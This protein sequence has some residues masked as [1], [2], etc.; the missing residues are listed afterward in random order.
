MKKQGGCYNQCRA[1]PKEQT[2]W[3]IKNIKIYL[4]MD[5]ELA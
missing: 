4:K 5:T 1:K 2:Q 3:Q